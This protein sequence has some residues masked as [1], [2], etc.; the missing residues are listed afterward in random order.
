MYHGRKKQAKEELTEEQLKEINAKL[1]KITTIN[2]T[3]LKKRHN[4]EFD[5]AS[6]DQ[7]EKFSF[8]SPDFQTLWN[9]RREILTH[10]MGGELKEQNDK[11]YEMVMKELEMLVKGIMRSPKSY[12]LWFHRQWIIEIG[13]GVERAL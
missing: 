5:R 2:Q 3:L 7:T 8:L 9:Y 11:K 10:I 6:L 12:T 13:L 4:K 1:Q